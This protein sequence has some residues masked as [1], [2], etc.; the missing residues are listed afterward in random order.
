MRIVSF[1]WF[2]VTCYEESLY[3]PREA[4]LWEWCFSFWF[5]GTLGT[6][7]WD[8]VPAFGG[9][10]YCVLT[11]SSGCA[12]SGFLSWYLRTTIFP[13]CITHLRVRFPYRFFCRP[14]TR[15]FL[16]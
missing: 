10:S 6:P 3:T 15:L 8:F 5:R 4:A 14:R 13:W 9:K 7:I 12:A 2:A 16:G 11:F 1:V